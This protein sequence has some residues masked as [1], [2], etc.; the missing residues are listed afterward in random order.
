MRETTGGSTGAHPAALLSS[1]LPSPPRIKKIKRKLAPVPVPGTLRAEAAVFCSLVLLVRF[2][3]L[4]GFPGTRPGLAPCDK[5]EPQFLNAS[6]CGTLSFFLLTYFA[7]RGKG[8]CNGAVRPERPHACL[9]CARC[10][11]RISRSKEECRNR[12][13]L[14]LSYANAA[15]ARR[16]FKASFK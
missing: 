6:S 3:V 4:A 1:S 7:R 10:C 5:R 8:R 12:P 13:D 14:L 11:S 16:V 15:K 9:L 2:F